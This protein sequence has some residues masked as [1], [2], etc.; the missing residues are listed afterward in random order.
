MIWRCRT[1]KH[2]WKNVNVTWNNL[3]DRSVLIN[4]YLVYWIYNCNTIQT[5]HQHT[6]QIVARLN[7]LILTVTRLLASLA[8]GQL[9]THNYKSSLMN[10]VI[11]G[12]VLC[13]VHLSCEVCEWRVIKSY[14]NWSFTTCWV[15]CA[16][17]PL[18]VKLKGYCCTP[19]A[20]SGFLT[21][22]LLR[23]QHARKMNAL[24]FFPDKCAK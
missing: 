5:A 7:V 17:I 24:S 21:T 22:Q 14:D 12:P 19:P 4:G 20:F 8:S 10:M 18:S 3:R 9:A 11:T 6:R 13:R 16:S 1:A 2:R 15:E 23:T